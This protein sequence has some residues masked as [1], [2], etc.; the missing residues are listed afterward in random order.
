MK[1][2]KIEKI[3]F[4]AFTIC[5][6]LFIGSNSVL[7]ASNTA[8]TYIQCGSSTFPA[9]LA[10]IIRSVILLLQIIIPI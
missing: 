3:L 1:K 4:Y 6:T 10:T 9:P 8:T 7:A 2:N 5:L